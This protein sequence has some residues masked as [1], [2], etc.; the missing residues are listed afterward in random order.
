M[1]HG[2]RCAYGLSDMRF[3]VEKPYELRALGRNYDERGG[4]ISLTGPIGLNKRSF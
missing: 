1:R 4:R 3:A 2:M